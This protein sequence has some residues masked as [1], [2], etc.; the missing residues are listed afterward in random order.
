MVLLLN[1]FSCTL[2][3]RRSTL[4]PV[5]IRFPVHPDPTSQALK[6]IF[7]QRIDDVTSFE[8]LILFELCYIIDKYKK[9]LIFSLGIRLL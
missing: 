8:I 9:N 7:Y 4:G 3:V 1:F 2:I 5:F 6:R